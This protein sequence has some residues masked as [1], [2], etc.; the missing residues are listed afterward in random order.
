VAHGKGGVKARAAGAE[1]IGRRGRDCRRGGWAVAVRRRGSKWRR[2]R[3]PEAKQSKIRNSSRLEEVGENMEK[4]IYM[5]YC[6]LQLIG[7]T[8]VNLAHIFSC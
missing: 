8:C 3:K 7:L 6:V 1:Q 5:G 2:D 4:F